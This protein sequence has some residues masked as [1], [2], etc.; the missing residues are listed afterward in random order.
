MYPEPVLYS[1]YVGTCETVGAHSRATR[2]AEWTYTTCGKKKGITQIP[3]A[4]CGITLTD[5]NR[6]TSACCSLSALIIVHPPPGPSARLFPPVTITTQTFTI[7]A[8]PVSCPRRKKDF[9]YT[10]HT[11]VNTIISYPDTYLDKGADD[12]YS[13][14]TSLRCGHSI[15]SPKNASPCAAF[16]I[17]PGPGYPNRGGLSAYQP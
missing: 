11:H 5:T 14:I 10:T 15:N 12:T 8:E 17:T 16:D 6:Q 2:H 13:S 4:T 3:Y 1:K 9:R 7:K